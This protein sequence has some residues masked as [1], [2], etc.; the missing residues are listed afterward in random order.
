MCMR[1]VKSSDAGRATREPRRE[2]E[3]E[4]RQPWPRGCVWVR[5]GARASWR[6]VATAAVAH[7]ETHTEKDTEKDTES[8]IERRTH[9]VR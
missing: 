7:T 6:A 5:V 9:R 4:S 3:E 2:H 8:K 1:E